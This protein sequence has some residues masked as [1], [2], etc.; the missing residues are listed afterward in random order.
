M[1]TTALVDRGIYAVV[2]HPQGGTAGILFSLALALIGQHWL[3]AVLAAV[4]MALIYV[5]ALRADEDCIDKF[6]DEYVH[7]MDRVPRVDFVTGLV[8]LLARRGWK[9]TG[10]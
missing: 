5:D 9:G 3:L 2:R 4:G 7:Y 10:P 1:E 8:R 6:G